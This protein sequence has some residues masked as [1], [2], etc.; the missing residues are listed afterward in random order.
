MSR[1]LGKANE[2]YVI[3]M[4]GKLNYSHDKYLR[5]DRS[6]SFSFLLTDY[7]LISQCKKLRQNPSSIALSLVSGFGMTLP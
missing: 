5:T 7:S 2:I 4:V 6:K 1:E 3:L